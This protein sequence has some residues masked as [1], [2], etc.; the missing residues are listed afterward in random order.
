MKQ[1]VSMHTTARRAAK[2]VNIY[3]NRLAKACPVQ[4]KV[5]GAPLHP[6]VGTFWYYMVL[7][8]VLF[9]FLGWNANQVHLLLT[10]MLACVKYVG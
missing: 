10:R 4:K 7:L 6:C 5:D 1:H 9:F 3:A 2:G 8:C